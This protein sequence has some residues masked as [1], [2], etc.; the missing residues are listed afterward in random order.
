VNGWKPQLIYVNVNQKTGTR[1]YQVDRNGRLSNPLPGTI[2]GSELSKDG[3][4]EFLMAS[5]ATT[6]G[7]CNMVQYK[8]GYDSSKQ[9][10]P[11]DALKIIT[12]EQCYNYPNWAGSIRFPA[13][14]QK[15]N[16][17]AK[18]VASQGESHIDKSNPLKNL[19]YYI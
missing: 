16:K 1:T 3:S 2:I 9:E 6:E 19:D 5:A 7:T 18:F 17:L 11:H 12:Y 15:A 10:V 13:P 8:V 14:L 4:Y